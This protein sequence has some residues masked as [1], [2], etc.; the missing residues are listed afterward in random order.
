[1]GLVVQKFGGSSVATP[2]KIRA[3]AQRAIDAKRDG[4]QVIVVVSAIGKT[5]DDLIALAERI[6]SNPPARE[7]AMLLATGEQLRKCWPRLNNSIASQPYRRMIT[8][9][10]PRSGQRGSS[11]AFGKSVCRL[12]RWS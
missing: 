9:A 5:T 6:S 2:E 1:M 11:T 10:I 7:M 8:T 12:A 3:A 4:N